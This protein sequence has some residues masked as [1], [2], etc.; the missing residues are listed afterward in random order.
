MPP[1][2]CEA[3]IGAY[4][5]RFVEARMMNRRK[6]NTLAVWRQDR[7]ATAARSRERC[8]MPGRNC[9]IR[10]AERAVSC[11]AARARLCLHRERSREREALPARAGAEGRM[12]G[13]QGTVDEGGPYERN[14]LR[15]LPVEHRRSGLRR[16][17]RQ[18]AAAGGVL[19]SD[20]PFLVLHP[21]RRR[22]ARV[23]VRCRARLETRFARPDHRR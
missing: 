22:T 5:L 17:D 12:D 16:R 10:F 21:F 15:S 1:V 3:L 7:C 23:R 9:P 13:E 8:G 4:A 14:R 6:D 20:H 2:P 11:P 19:L 18:P